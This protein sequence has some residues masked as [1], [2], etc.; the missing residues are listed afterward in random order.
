MYIYGVEKLVVYKLVFLK[1][2]EMSSILDGLIIFVSMYFLEIRMDVLG[3]KNSVYFL[4][5]GL[6]N[7][8]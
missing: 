8:M 4:K 7:N 5:Y 6:C 2:E 3:M 1:W